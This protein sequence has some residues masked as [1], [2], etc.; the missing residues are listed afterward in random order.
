MPLL[1]RI[2]DT[3]PDT[4]IKETAA[5]VRVLIATHGYVSVSS[6]DGTAC[7]SAEAEP[8]KP[9]SVDSCPKDTDTGAKS[10]S[11]PLIE[12]IGSS[13]DSVSR[14]SSSRSTSSVFRTSMK[15]VADV[16]VP[17]RG[18]ALLMLRRLVDSD[19]AEALN[20]TAEL[21]AVCDKT[22][23]DPDS[24]VY[25]NT[26]QLLSSLAT[27]LPQQAL[28][29]L[30]DRYLAVSH[31]RAADV[32]SR[33][34]AGERRMKLGEVLVKT[35]SALGTCVVRNCFFIFFFFYDGLC[36][37]GLFVKLDVFLC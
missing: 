4:A 22:I 17:V 15:E 30:A 31:S 8:S 18:H 6:Y 35:S 12:V 24:C 20:S 19:D 28:P 36:S 27:R 23:D 7:H 1:Q 5:D 26:I 32:E 14:Q 13:E 37:S 34:M 16:L 33:Q 3:H 2:V 21:L 11:K 25:L 9:T 29:W 10:K